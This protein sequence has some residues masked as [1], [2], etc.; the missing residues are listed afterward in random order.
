[1]DSAIVQEL[2]MYGTWFSGLGAFSVVAYSLLSNRP[3]LS[4]SIDEKYCLIVTN[5]KLVTSH[6]TFIRFTT[7]DLFTNPMKFSTNNIL[8]DIPKKE[9]EVL[10]V[11]IRSGEL[12]RIQL[13]LDALIKAYIRNYNLYSVDCPTQMK[14]ATLLVHV[15]G[16]KSFKVSLPD[17][18]YI[19][20]KDNLFTR[21]YFNLNSLV[22]RYRNH[23]IE[24]S[25]VAM[26]YEKQ[27]LEQYTIAY[28]RNIC[29]FLPKRSIS[30]V[31]RKHL[32]KRFKKIINAWYF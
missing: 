29:L 15:A 8:K 16:R 27:T 10:D 9:N 32:K 5:S 28:K 13:S 23:Y 24:M 21:Y 17:K 22:E 18:F 19:E 1:M 6:I 31:F 3:S 7:D 4:L 30:S 14:R 11:E 2:T 25:P 20:V 12:K 26:E